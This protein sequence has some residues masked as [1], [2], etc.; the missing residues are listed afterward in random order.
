MIT[1]N[2][3]GTVNTKCECEVVTITTIV[4]DVG[5]VYNKL[6]ENLQK[7][8][9]KEALLAIASGKFL[10]SILFYILVL[11][12]AAYGYLLFWCWS[13]D[14]KDTGFKVEKKDKDLAY[15]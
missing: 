6:E 8:F 4:N 10:K 1:E 12:T 7:V 3:D 9:S 5:G 14:L 11:Q 2:Q 13:Q 15:A